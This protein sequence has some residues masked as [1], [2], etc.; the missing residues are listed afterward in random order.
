[1]TV[2]EKVLILLDS[3]VIIH[4]FKA[5]KISLLFE[6]YPDRL[7]MLDVVL[8]E[9]LKNRTVNKIVENLFLLKQV[10]VISYPTELLNEYVR[11]KDKIRGEGE[12][13]CLIY[14][15]HN[16]HIIASSNTSDIIPFCE[17]NSIAYLTTLDIFSVA[18]H[19]KLITQNEANEFI[20]VILSK[21]SFLCCSSIDEHIK[22]HFKND[23]LLY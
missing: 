19:R 18:I 11:L 3:D 20:K 17:E 16:Q 4:L 2:N 9:L 10:T 6:L 8:N 5:G 15:K 21:N 23:K 14:C 22:R 1:M 12:R 7:R 13:A